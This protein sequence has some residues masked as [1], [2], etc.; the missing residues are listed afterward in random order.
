MELE[1]APAAYLALGVTIFGAGTLIV[2]M[3]WQLISAL[4]QG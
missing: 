1:I 2:G 3:I 4:R